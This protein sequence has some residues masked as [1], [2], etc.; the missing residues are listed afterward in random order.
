MKR[1]KVA[2]IYQSP[3]FN[4]D[5]TCCSVA[6]GKQ[7]NDWMIIILFP[8]PMHEYIESKLKTSL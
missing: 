6:D 7:S 5:K 8:S 1:A 2:F 3:A 4:F